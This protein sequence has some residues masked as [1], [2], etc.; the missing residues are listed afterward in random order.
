MNIILALESQGQE[1]ELTSWFLGG[2]MVAHYTWDCALKRVQ[3]QAV[4]QSENL[5]QWQQK[6][7]KPAKQLNTHYIFLLL[8]IK[9]AT[10][11]DLYIE[12]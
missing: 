9:H 4:L 2:Y 7:N 6:T 12:E 5:Y 1:I 11:S 8:T 10:F 3:G